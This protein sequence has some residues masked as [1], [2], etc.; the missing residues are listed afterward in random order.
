MELKYEVHTNINLI[1]HLL[2]KLKIFNSIIPED[3]NFIGIKETLTGVSV[4]YKIVKSIFF[5]VLYAVI[6]NFILSI[7]T[8]LIGLDANR[9]NIVMSA[10]FVLYVIF[11]SM[12]SSVL[13]ESEK[14][15]LFHE[16]FRQ[17]AKDLARIEL[18]IGPLTATLG[19][20]AG[21]TVVF[22]L[23]SGIPFIEVLIY[24]L[25]ILTITMIANWLHLK[26]FDKGVSLQENV[27]YTIIVIILA[28]ALA[29][30]IMITRT[31]ITFLFRN[32]FTVIVSLGLLGAAYF[33]NWNYKN[34]NLIAKQAK[35]V[36][37]RQM[38]IRSGSLRTKDV[39]LKESDLEIGE[40]ATKEMEKASKLHGY[41]K[42]NYLFFS[43]HRR[44][45]LKQLLVMGGIVLAIAVIGSIGL[46]YNKFN[47]IL[48]SKAMGIIFDSIRVII[49]YYM[50]VSMGNERLAKSMFVNCDSSLLTYSFYRRPADI[51]ESYNQRLKEIVKLNLPPTIAALILVVSWLLLSGI[52][53][54]TDRILLI[55]L[56][57]TL[58][59][60]FT[61]HQ[62]FIYYIFQ[63]YN[64]DVKIKSPIYSIINVVVYM[65]C[66]LPLILKPPMSVYTIVAVIL[67]VIYAVVSRILIPKMA[68][69]T[70]RVK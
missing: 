52:P 65:I 56:I 23:M 38:E 67:T 49:P 17:P 41:A 40:K 33:G 44:I 8:N 45:L 66:Y 53:I 2:R 68:P 29:I 27:P 22:S 47:P 55:P 36:Y 64:N 61:I 37:E 19:R 32:P 42:L 11:N 60:F 20:L 9:A 15:L 31:D 69:R 3:S 34:Y 59:A 63:P 18:L 57:I 14:I 48:D 30:V 1:F 24:T 58:Y 5:G 70:F 6:V 25:V 28:L 10:M 4:L 46:I 43:R 35:N 13:G 7:Y 54:T 26:L 62:L 39:E 12:Q 50:Y 51:L 16:V 21:F